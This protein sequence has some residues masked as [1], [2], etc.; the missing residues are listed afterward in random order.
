[1]I[2]DAFCLL[3]KDLCKISPTKNETIRN[4]FCTLLF[5]IVGF[6]STS[7]EIYNGNISFLKINKIFVIFFG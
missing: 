6:H 3:H 4:E 1:M 5:K 7:S 2:F